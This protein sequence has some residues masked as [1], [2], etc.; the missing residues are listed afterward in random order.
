[1]RRF[2]YIVAAIAMVVACAEKEPPVYTVG[3]HDNE[4]V[5]R[6]QVG[7][8]DKDVQTKANDAEHSKH[9]AFKENTMLRMLVKGIWTGHSPEEVVKSTSAKTVAETGESK[10][11]GLTGWSPKLFWDDFGTADPA[12]SATGRA[13][14]LTIYGAAV[15]G[16][17]V[18]PTVDNWEAM[19]WTLDTDQS[20]GWASED[21]LS[22]NNITSDKDGTLKF[23][24]RNSAEASNLLI[25]T[26]AMAKVTV[27]LTAADGFPGYETGLDNAI[28]EATPSVTLVGF[29]NSGTYNIKT[30]TPTP[31]NSSEEIKPKKIEGGAGNHIAVYDALVFPG[32]S[33][34]DSDKVLEI[35]ADGN[36]YNVT[37][38]KINEAIAGDDNR[39]MD[40]KNYVFNILVKKTEVVVEATVK[41]WDEP[42]QA[43]EEAPVIDIDTDFGTAGTAFTGAFDLY[44]STVKNNGYDENNTAEGVNWASTYTYSPET[45]WSN[46][47]AIYW[48]NHQT[49]YFFRGVYPA[50]TQVQVADPDYDYINVNNV[51]F[52]QGT[53]PSDLMIAMPLTGNATCTHGKDVARYGICATTGKI[54]LNFSHAMSK[55]EVRLKSSDPSDAN[56]VDLS[57]IKVEIVGGYD[58][59]R[60]AM[61]SGIH[62]D[63][64]ASEKANYYQLHVTEAAAESGYKKTTL[65]AVVPQVLY[66]DVYFKITVYNATGNDIYTKQI[67]TIKDSEGSIINE[68]KPGEHYIYSLKIT[69][70]E[71]FVTATL[72]D[73]K[74]VDSSEDIWM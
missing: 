58:K 26:H 7:E 6:S 4:I 67:N 48:P 31:Q 37:A 64:D 15:D 71:I 44:R 17:A 5:L 63:F 50:G 42:I 40:G 38:A 66:D 49:H 27:R 65:D 2:I 70:S 62:L 33:F 52:E 53:H 20:D 45:G 13:Q 29:Y 68:W 21:L 72:T 36:V 10:H 32:N 18:G 55:L 43:Q 35:N 34:R 28:F 9:Q 25:F 24:Q 41:D 51:K 14:G 46:S 22:S 16:L 3:E 47:P 8:P 54:T 61:V 74:T 1:M 11:N 59:G 73:W 60:I 12:N 23:E 56:Y 69:K 57:A 30:K 39:F 19:S